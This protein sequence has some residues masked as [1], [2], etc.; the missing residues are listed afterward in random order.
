MNSNLSKILI[1]LAMLA[2]G[3]TAYAGFFGPFNDVP[4][5]SVLAL[6]GA[7]AAALV[8]AHWLRRK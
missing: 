7:G 6:F 4:E 3:S 2:A 8:M 1:T 5:P